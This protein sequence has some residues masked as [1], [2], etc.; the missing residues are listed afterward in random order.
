MSGYEMRRHPEMRSFIAFDRSKFLHREC[1]CTICDSVREEH[2]VPGALCTNSGVMNVATWAIDGWNVWGP[3]PD[4]NMPFIVIGPSV[5]GTRGHRP[6]AVVI[7][8]M[9]EGKL[10]L[11]LTLQTWPTAIGIETRSGT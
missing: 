5:P 2:V 9:I 7:L 1:T 10:E 8:A 6:D 4:P 3:N 11:R